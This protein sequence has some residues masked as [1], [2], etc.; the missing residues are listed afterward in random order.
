MNEHSYQKS[1]YI[2]IDRQVAIDKLALMLPGK[3]NDRRQTVDIAALDDL[4]EPDNEA[5]VSNDPLD[6]ILKK[7]KNAPFKIRG[8][9]KSMSARIPASG[10]VHGYV[11][12]EDIID[13]DHVQ[14]PTTSTAASLSSDSNSI[15]STSHTED[16]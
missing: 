16:A 12:D 3:V 5:A 7:P 8:R 15:Q 6:S 13:M 1:F 4:P 2:K 11:S 10:L 14:M 9:R